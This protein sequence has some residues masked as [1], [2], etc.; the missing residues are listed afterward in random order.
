MIHALSH[1]TRFASDPHL[2]RLFSSVGVK[3]HVFTVSPPSSLSSTWNGSASS[4]LAPPPSSRSINSSNDSSFY[5]SFRCLSCAY[6]SPCSNLDSFLSS[7]ARSERPPF[8]SP[9]PSRFLFSCSDVSVRH[10]V[11]VYGESEGSR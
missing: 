2:Y 7:L 11:R 10:W 3:F 9:S 4:K 1:P 5:H 8:P 6:H